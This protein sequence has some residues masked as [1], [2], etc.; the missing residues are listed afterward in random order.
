MNNA[1]VQASPLQ[2]LHCNIS[3]NYS[4]TEIKS[5]AKSPRIKRLGGRCKDATIGA[6]GLTTSNK[7]DSGSKNHQQRQ[8]RVS[9]VD[10]CQSRYSSPCT[11]GHAIFIPCLVARK[12]WSIPGA[13]S[14]STSSWIPTE[15][16]FQVLEHFG[17]QS[18]K[19]YITGQNRE[20]FFRLDTWILD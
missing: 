10:W 16:S 9:V 1:Q 18:H 19:E 13:T 3:P 12:T 17:T 4:P 14:W 5:D 8:P 15:D 2:S 6:P 11:T 20:T 7:R